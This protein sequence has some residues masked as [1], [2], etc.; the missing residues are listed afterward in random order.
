MNNNKF[1]NSKMGKGNDRLGYDQTL[2]MLDSRIPIL[3]DYA[4]SI[5]DPFDPTG[6]K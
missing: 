5:Y 1:L 3:S 4:K 2:G 6:Y